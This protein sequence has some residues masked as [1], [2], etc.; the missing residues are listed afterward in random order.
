MGHSHGR[1]RISMLCVSNNARCW[2]SVGR[3][4]A[5][6]KVLAPEMISTKSSK[7]KI[8]NKLTAITGVL[9]TL[10]LGINYDPSTFFIFPETEEKTVWFSFQRLRT[11]A[12]FPCHVEGGSDVS[13][14]SQVLFQ[15]P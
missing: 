3:D 14:P 1:W 4:L 8:L 15:P 10:I 7:E 9:D 6:K 2:I 13:H 5:A 12:T 11:L